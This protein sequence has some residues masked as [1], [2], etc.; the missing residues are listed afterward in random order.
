MPIRTQQFV[1]PILLGVCAVVLAQDPPL[2]LSLQPNDLLSPNVNIQEHENR[3][4]EE[5]SV[6]GNVYMV[7]VNPKAGPSYY[8]VDP[9]GS[10]DFEMRRD[11][12]GADL[13]VP[14][15]ALVRW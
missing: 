10:G 7:R 4:T 13:N 6:N 11:V 5:F 3:A 9:D 1:L 15:W 12:P 14:Q 8:L 2:D